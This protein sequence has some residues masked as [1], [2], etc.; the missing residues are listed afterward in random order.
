MKILLSNN[1]YKIMKDSQ[2]MIMDMSSIRISH[3]FMNR[4]MSSRLFKIYRNKPQIL[5]S[6]NF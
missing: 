1:S 3:L 4:K 2:R 6:I 5:K